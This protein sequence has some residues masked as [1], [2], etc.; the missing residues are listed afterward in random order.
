MFFPL[1]VTTK[2]NKV[3]GKTAIW[4]IYLAEMVCNSMCRLYSGDSNVI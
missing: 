4:K 2:Q 1:R 3:T